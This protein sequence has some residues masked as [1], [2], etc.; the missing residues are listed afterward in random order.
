MDPLNVGD[1]VKIKRWGW[2]QDCE[3]VR[4]LCLQM[5]GNEDLYAFRSRIGGPHW[6][7]Q[8]IKALTGG[9]AAVDITTH[10]TGLVIDLLHGGNCVMLVNEQFVLVGED[11]LQLETYGS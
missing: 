1:I 11:L 5:V 2:M 3:P 6:H 10:T 8:S 4:L 9:V 7:W